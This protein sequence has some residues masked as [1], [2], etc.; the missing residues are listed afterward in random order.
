MVALLHCLVLIFFQMCESLLQHM[1]EGTTFDL[2]FISTF[3]LFLDS[4]NC[5]LLT[6]LF[7]KNWCRNFG[8]FISNMLWVEQIQT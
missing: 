3:F 7:I 8:T 6:E 2:C 1:V 4:D 5:E